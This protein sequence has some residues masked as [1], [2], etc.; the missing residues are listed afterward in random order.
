M[1]ISRTEQPMSPH[2]LCHA[3]GV[4][5]G[6]TDPNPDSIPSMQTLLASC[7]GLVTVDEEESAV[8]LVHFTLQEYLNSRSDIFQNPYV[9]MA[10]VWLLYLNFDCIRQLPP[11]LDAAPHKYLF[12]RHASCYWGLYARNQTTE[13]VKSLALQLLDGFDSHISACLLLCILPGELA[14]SRTGFT[15]LHCMAYIGVDEIAEALLDIRDWDVDGADCWGR[16]PLICA[17]MN[18]HEGIIKV[19][20]EKAGATLNKA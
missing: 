16:T 2:E 11:I 15:G 4:Q 1:W 12:L 13:C 6:F 19:L 18:G 14:G 7:L 8:R 5:T 17:S 10:Q 3:L 9:L 20:L